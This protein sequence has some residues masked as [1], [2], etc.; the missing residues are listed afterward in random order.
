ML[1]I[2][3]LCGA[4]LV[5]VLGVTVVVPAL[6]AIADDLGTSG[7]LVVTGY[8]AAFGG[9]LILAGRL[10]DRLG[11]RR[12]LMAGLAVFATASAAAGLAPSAPWL[13]AARCVQGAGAAAMIPTALSLLVAH[14]GDRHARAVAWWTAVGA[15]GGGS[16]FLVGGVLTDLA[17]W[18]WVLLVNVPVAVVLAIGVATTVR[19]APRQPGT[20]LDVAGGAT[21]TAALIVLVLAVSA[22]GPAVVAGLAAAAL[23]AVAFALVER[24]ARD[25]ICPP[26]TWSDRRL[27]SAAAVALVNNAS[28]GAAVVVAA[29]YA[30][31]ELGLSPSAGGLVLLSFNAAVIAGSAIATRIASGRPARLMTTGLAAIAAAAL[32]LV[33]ATAAVPSTATLSAGLALLGAGLGV[34]AVGSTTLGTSGP[35]RRRGMSSALI[36][37][38]AQ[39]GT[40]AG[41]AVVL[42]LTG[43][44]GHH[45][46]WLLAAA[47]A[48]AGLAIARPGATSPARRAGRLGAC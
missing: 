19:P 36:N 7:E 5:N 25:P 26:E 12:V 2:V 45:T 29:G 8:A 16:G 13:V 37:T 22:N 43:T 23:L 44:G 39:I 24:R 3:V 48:A 27:T 17:G 9:L 21:V 6:P 42:A 15:V 10:G 14:A 35:E 20:G 4:E 28:T 41:V 38:G 31:R 33:A 11:H 30:Q 40:A 1:P 47:I 46:G 32:A 18:R 34:S